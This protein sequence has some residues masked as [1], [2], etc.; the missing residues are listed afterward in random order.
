MLD[1]ID[2]FNRHVRRVVPISDA[3]SHKGA[4]IIGTRWV[5]S[6]KNDALDPDVRARLVA[7]EISMYNDESFFAATPP[8]ESKRMLFSQYS[9]EKVRDGLP[10]KLSVMD[11]RKT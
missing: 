10:L 3:L 6:N 7:Q 1:E 8:L 11:V 9:S 5:L 2:Y 4:K